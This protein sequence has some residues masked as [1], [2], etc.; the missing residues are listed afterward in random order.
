LERNQT[1]SVSKEEIVSVMMK[2]MTTWIGDEPV[3]C[4]R[5][6]RRATANTEGGGKSPVKESPYKKLDSCRNF[7]CFA[8]VQD[9]A[10]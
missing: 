10:A 3:A 7:L 4:C 2:P 9:G 6:L 5:I 8:S 1:E